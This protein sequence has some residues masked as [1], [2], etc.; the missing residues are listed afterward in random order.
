MNKKTFFH[1]KIIIRIAVIQ[2]I[3]SFILIKYC[4]SNVLAY[5][6]NSTNNL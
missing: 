2:V 5:V 1:N 3:M 6:Y 4:N